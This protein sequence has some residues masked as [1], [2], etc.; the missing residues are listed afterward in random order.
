MHLTRSSVIPGIGLFFSCFAKIASIAPPDSCATCI[1]ILTTVSVGCSRNFSKRG[2]HEGRLAAI[3]A[4]DVRM[5][6]G[7]TKS[8]RSGNRFQGMLEDGL[9][10]PWIPQQLHLAEVIT[11]PIRLQWL[12][13]LL[14]GIAFVQKV[15]HSLSDHL[16]V[17]L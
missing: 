17:I 11:E 14:S 9:H 1:A 3:R 4:S 13:P 15:D 8:S 2:I 12:D 6:L 16:A 7:S 10:H 5:I